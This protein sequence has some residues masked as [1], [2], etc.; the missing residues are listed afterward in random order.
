MSTHPE[1][2]SNML[3]QWP[4]TVLG[5]VRREVKKPKENSS[6]RMIHFR[7]VEVGGG[8]LSSGLFALRSPTGLGNK[9]VLSPGL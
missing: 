1:Q 2:Q 6:R 4:Q 9:E 3:S 8:A 5:I 7:C